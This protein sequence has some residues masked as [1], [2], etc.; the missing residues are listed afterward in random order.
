MKA[1][2]IRLHENGSPSVMKWE[3]VELGDPGRGEI[4]VR[5]TAVGFNMVDTYVRSGL[6][7]SPAKPCGLGAE[8]AGVVEAVG[9]GVKGFKAGDRVCYAFGTPQGAYAEARIMPTGFVLKTPGWLDDRVAAAVLTKGRT[10][11]YLFNRTHKLKKGETILFHAAA[12]GVGTFAGQW[13]KSVGARAIGVVSTEEKAKIARRNGYA[14]VIVTANTDITEEVMRI[15]RGE[16]V[17]VVYDSV[18]KDTWQASLE[19]VRKL[20]LVVSFGSASGSPPPF[21]VAA[22]GLKKSAFI[23]RATMVNYMTSEEI[24]AAS[25]RKVFSMI[26]KG[27]LKPRIDATYKLSDAA[28]VHRD[29]EARKTT[30][31][32]VM[33]P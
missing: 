17:D 32:I 33:I 20:G 24:A 16:G 23:H 15:T 30:G 26:K 31:Q 2:A 21:D 3:S 6:Y 12:G 1:K 22:D 4:L 29:A 13:A 11:E 9:K 14:H 18:G 5:N 25:A 19:S 27:A 28:R 8:A 7:P 10:V